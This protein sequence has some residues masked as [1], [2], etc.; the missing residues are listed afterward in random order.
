MRYKK[1]EMNES[2]RNTLEYAEARVLLLQKAVLRAEMKRINSEIKKLQYLSPDA[3]ETAKSDAEQ[4]QQDI[5]DDT[6]DISSTL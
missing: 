5:P 1:H 2:V 6:P 3:V 4:N